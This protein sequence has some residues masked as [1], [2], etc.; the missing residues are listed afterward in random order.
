MKSFLGAMT[1]RPSNAAAGTTP[2]PLTSRT[3]GG[4]FGAFTRHRGAAQ[5]LSAMEMVGTVFGIV[6]KLATGVSLV[7]WHLWKKAKSGKKEDRTE[8][9]SHAALDTWNHPN[10]FTTRQVLVEIGQQHH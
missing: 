7:D 2:V 8:V 10:D 6:D 4:L 5:E 1:A 3:A 9:T